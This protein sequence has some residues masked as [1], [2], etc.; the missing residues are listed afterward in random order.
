ME[1]RKER[2]KLDTER[3]GIQ[4]QPPWF[5]YVT[6][7]QL[8]YTG[9]PFYVPI[10]RTMMK[11]MDIYNENMND[12]WEPYP[13]IEPGSSAWKARRVTVRPPRLP[14]AYK[15][16]TLAFTRNR[17]I[18]IALCGCFPSIGCQLYWYIGVRKED[19]CSSRMRD[20]LGSN[21]DQKLSQSLVVIT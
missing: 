20:I 1:E 7:V 15:R 9:S 4:P 16:Y 18:L 8:R 2:Q 17:G 5:F 11:T 19:M 12:M 6:G 14:G 21:P 10:R 13:G 3:H